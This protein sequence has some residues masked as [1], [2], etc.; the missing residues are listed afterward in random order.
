MPKKVKE[1]P[2]K[3]CPRCGVKYS[4]V[5]RRKIGG[6]APEYKPFSLKAS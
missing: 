3:M 5:E 2:A 6:N 4:Y 1:K